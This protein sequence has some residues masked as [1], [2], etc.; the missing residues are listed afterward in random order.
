M[1]KNFL[2]FRAV[3]LVVAHCLLMPILAIAQVEDCGTRFSGTSDPLAGYNCSTCD[4]PSSCQGGTVRLFFHFI[5]RSDGSGGQPA[6]QITPMLNLANATY[7]PQGLVFVSEGSDE[8]RND[9]L[10]NFP[11][12]ATEDEFFNR[13]NTVFSTNSRSNAI[14]VYIMGVNAQN[15]G[16]NINLQQFRVNGVAQNIVSKALVMASDAILISTFPHEVGHCLGLFH[17]HEERAFGAELVRRNGN[18]TTAGDLI[19]DTPADFNLDKSTVNVDPSSCNYRGNRRDAEGVL[20]TP[21]S[22]NIMSYSL[23]NCR[24]TFS[25]GQATRVTTALQSSSIL[26]PV[27]TANTCVA[28][29]TLP[30]NACYK[31][32][33]AQTGK[34]L[35]AM[36]DNTIQQQNANN[37]N[38]QI[39]RVNSQ[40]GGRVSFVAQDGTNRAIQA[41][42]GGNYGE[43]LQLVGA[44][45]NNLQKWAVA[46]N[47][48]NSSQWRVHNAS[49]NNTWDMQNYGN[50]PYLQIWGSTAEPFVPYR[51]FNFESATCP[52]T[53]T[54]TPV[55]PTPV[56][57]CNLPTNTCYNI[58]VVHTGKLL[59]KMGDNTIQQQNA[60][61]QNNQIWRIT[62]PGNTQLAFTAQDGDF[63]AIQAPNG[64]NYGELLGAT[65]GSE[66]WGVQCDPNDGT[67]WRVYKPGSNNTWDIQS[68]GNDPYLQIWGN[69]SEGFVPYR[70]FRFLSA[71]CPTGPFTDPVATCSVSNPAG[72]FDVAN[73]TYVAGWALD[74]SDFN[75]T[76]TVDVFVDGTKIGSVQANGDRSDLPAAFG[77]NQAARYHGYTYMLPKNGAWR[78]GQNHTISTRICGTTSDQAGSPKTIGGCNSGARLSAI[79]L[80]AVEQLQIVPNPAS[81]I[82]SA[83]FSLSKGEQGQLRVVSLL[84]TVLWESP[85]VG[86]GDMQ[87]RSFEVSQY[88]TGI[89][90]VSLQTG[91]RSQT[92]RML[93]TR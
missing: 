30:T 55:T 24:T 22:R 49:N 19:C 14:D 61:N 29:C 68:F 73:C 33:V 76:V 81:G 75:K 74:Q 88:A 77:G 86:T 50:D 5:R 90:M 12:S 83:Q 40:D 3:W 43:L 10:F 36:G 58:Q 18:C 11:V 52:T 48:A 37:Q 72:A 44:S 26:R 84:G 69:T 70:S 4:A 34:R 56:S 51:S 59:Q 62:G 64:G 25:A 41:N 46:C 6:T 2:L 45:N 38:S 31:I 13:L 80:D 85:V 53:T 28:N 63:G 8:I 32:Q 79:P 91:Q 23:D 92:V 47:P 17:T 60:N 9:N 21:D 89:Y 93:V 66:S 65:G 78:D 42:S 71:T 27:F 1:M 39:W 35:Q 87:T 82:A 16:F 15:F 54:P 67:R 7:Q 20:Y 57:N